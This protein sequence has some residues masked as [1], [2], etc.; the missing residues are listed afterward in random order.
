MKSVFIKSSLLFIGLLL[1]C[2]KEEK[3]LHSQEDTKNGFY[4]RFP[5]I[6][7]KTIFIKNENTQ[8][9]LDKILNKSNVQYYLGFENQKLYPVPFIRDILDYEPVFATRLNKL[10]DKEFFKTPDSSFVIKYEYGTGHIIWNYLYKIQ[11]NKI[12]LDKIFFMEPY[13]STNDTI[14]YISQ[15][16]VNKLINTLNIKA[17]QDSMTKMENRKK[18]NYKFILKKK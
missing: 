9:E 17:I 11:E 10:I 3:Q 13:N 5:F 12:Y 1:S 6:E 8:L 7:K 4:V 14:A 2:S 16:N 15:V 18:E